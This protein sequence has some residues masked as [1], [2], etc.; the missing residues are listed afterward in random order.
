[1]TTGKTIALTFFGK[2]MSLLRGLC[3]CGG[4]IEPDHQ[5]EI[6]VI[7]QNEGK[8]DLLINKCDQIT[9][10]LVLPCAIDKIQKQEAPTLFT[11]RDNGGFGYTDEIH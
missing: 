5:G 9:Q 11:V 4:V 6:Q 2:V 7:V 1:M 10:L 8:D 3:V